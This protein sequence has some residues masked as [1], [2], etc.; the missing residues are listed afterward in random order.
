[1]LLSGKNIDISMSFILYDDLIVSPDVPMIRQPS[2]APVIRW[3]SASLLSLC[4]TEGWTVLMEVTRQAT[5]CQSK[6]LR[7]IE[8]SIIGVVK[9]FRGLVPL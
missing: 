6:S 7:F 8:N 2:T 9:L 5:V 1:M 4:V 3:R